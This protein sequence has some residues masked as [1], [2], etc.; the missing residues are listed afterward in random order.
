MQMIHDCIVQD[1]TERWQR[2]E[3]LVHLLWML[4]LSYNKAMKGELLVNISSLHNCICSYSHEM[5]TYRIE[6][7]IIFGSDDDLVVLS[8][9]DETKFLL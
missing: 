3:E 4:L 7:N 9:N 8:Q 6:E 2:W 5:V 1:G